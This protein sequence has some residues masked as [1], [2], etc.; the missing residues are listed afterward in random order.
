MKLKIKSTFL[1]A[2]RGVEVREYSEGS[3]VEADDPEL[4]AVATSE[5]WAAPADQPEG[6]AKKAAPENKAKG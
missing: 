1:F 3:V 6:K 5:G 4:I 2:H